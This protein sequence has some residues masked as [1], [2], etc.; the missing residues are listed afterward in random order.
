[1][2]DGIF[3][4]IKRLLISQSEPKP[5]PERKAAEDPAWLAHWQQDRQHLLTVAPTRESPVLPLIRPRLLFAVDAT[6]SREW[7]WEGSKKVTDAL[8]QALPGRLDIA[9]CVHRGERVHTF[10]E[11]TPDAAKLRKRAAGIKCQEGETRLLPILARVT[12]ETPAAQVMIY[13]GDCFEESEEKA[14]RLADKLKAQG[15][16]V[17]ILQDG[18]DYRA[19]RVFAGIAAR[20]GGVVLPF[21]LT[22]LEKL[23][24]LLAAVAVLAVGGEKLLE[25]KRDTMPGALVLLGHLS[26]AQLKGRK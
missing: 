10:T 8:F 24:E 5:E 9:L 16:K 20:T 6:G 21:D 23:R 25:A 11:Y 19:K 4:G 15:T 3:E 17:I 26:A 1:M 12:K 22:S 18:Y 13:I 7:A 2:A 14:S